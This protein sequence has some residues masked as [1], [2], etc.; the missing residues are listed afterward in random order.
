M[1]LMGRIFTDFY[2]GWNADDADGADL[3]GFFIFD[4]LLDLCSMFY[5]T[6]MGRIFT[7]GFC[8]FHLY[9]WWIQ[10]KRQNRNLVLTQ[11]KLRWFD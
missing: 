2:W 8:N 9:L 3:R 10:K 1:T 7:K 6:L 4:Y 11:S 5:R